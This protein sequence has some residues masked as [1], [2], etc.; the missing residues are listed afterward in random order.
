[1][2][3]FLFTL[4]ALLMASSAFATCVFY[5]EDFD[6]PKDMVNKNVSIDIQADF[7][8][9]V[10]AWQ[11]T[12][13]LPEGLQLVGVKKGADMTLTYTDEFGDEATSA[14]D[15]TRQGNKLIVAVMV[16]NYDA[17]GNLYGV[18]KWGPGHYDQM[19]ILV[20]KA[21]EDYAGGEVTLET[22]FACGRDTRPEID[23]N[24]C[25]NEP[26]TSEPAIVQFE[27]TTAPAPTFSYDADTYTM[28]ATCEG[29]EVELYAN[30]TKV[31]NPY[32]VEQTEEE[33]EIVFSAITLKNEEDNNSPETFYEEN[34]VIVPAKVVVT[35]DA[36]T[37]W[38]SQDD[39]FI[40]LHFELA[41]NAEEGTELVIYNE[42]GD[43]VEGPVVAVARPEYDPDAAEVHA[44]FTAYAVLNDVQSAALNVDEI[45][46]QKAQV[47][48]QTATPT[49]QIVETEEGFEITAT[50]DGTITLYVNDEVVAEG[51]SP[52]TYTV[53][54][55]DYPDGEEIPVTATALEDGKTISEWAPAQTIEVLATLQGAI[56]FGEVDQETG[57]F[58][59][60][61]NGNEDV[62]I[63]LNNEEITLAR[64][65]NFTYQLPDY[66][67]YE[68][69]ATAAAEG[70]YD[71]SKDATL[72]WTKPAPE[73]TAT[74]TVQIVETEEGFEI[75]VTGDGVITL[76]VNDEVVAEEEGP[77]TYTVLK[78]DYP[79]GEEIPVTA[80]AQEP[81]KEISEWAP[82]QTIEILATLKG[83]INFGEVDQ[84]TGRFDVSYNGN[85]DVTITLNNEEITLVRGENFTYQLPAYGTYDVTATAA[86]EGYYDKS[87]DATLVWN[88]PVTPEQTAAPEVVTTPG[89]DAYT[90]TGQV[91]AGDPEAEVTIFVWDEE[92]E[93]WVAVGN[94]FI[95][96]RTEEEQTIKIKVVS[97]IEGQTDGEVTMD[98]TVPAKPADPG[99]G[100][101]ELMNGKA[102][103]NVRYFN[104]AGQEMQEA[105]GVTI[106][107]TTYT[108]GT[109]SAVKVMK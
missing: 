3:K 73:V 19:M 75:T 84:E 9:Y 88:A 41:E 16:G 95:V 6:I 92:E 102:V 71:K 99:T 24:R 68:V 94:P 42:N 97:H 45:V 81:G 51:E 10:S 66:G 105:N 33:Q 65:A 98:V 80:T 14:P 1:M 23:E 74:P 21:A 5:I 96:N 104:M 12:I 43:E 36:P 52:V 20:V 38:V 69:T 54:K 28:T 78:A 22:E 59:V 90:I 93:D 55:A 32:T 87:K 25:T 108:D 109:T 31:D 107:V 58:D 2:K 101:N 61:Y 40:Y 8:E 35:P 60:S 103:A 85:E 100:V 34:P 77:V 48:E 27:Q 63:T 15:I 106:V 89:D 30:G 4:A 56:N 47:L 44:I 53:L 37:Y 79:D 11:L 70:Y 62:T 82:A 64:G 39:D 46:P 50:G 57:R 91:K 7:E 76:Y 13:H 67:T 26:V 17:D 29:Y 18:A 72:V 83:A 49:V 86:A